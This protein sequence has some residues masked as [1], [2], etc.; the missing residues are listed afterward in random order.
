MCDIQY[1][2]PFRMHLQA[3]ALSRIMG[4]MA[5]YFLL[6]ALFNLA[7]IISESY[8][9]FP[10]YIY[11]NCTITRNF[12]SNTPY[13]FTLNTL[14]SSLSSHASATTTTFYNKNYSVAKSVDTIDR[15]N[16]FRIIAGQIPSLFTRNK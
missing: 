3:A 2:T 14:L 5:S 1:C 9:N 10:I 4:S 11:S 8:T 15:R 12:T 6:L 16:F 13:Q 7:V